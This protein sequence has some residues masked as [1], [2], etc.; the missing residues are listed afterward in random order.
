MKTTNQRSILS[1]FGPPK[2]NGEKKTPDS[3]AKN[4]EAIKTVDEDSPI[5]RKTKRRSR[6]IESDSEDEVIDNNKEKDSDNV[7]EE[8]N[9]DSNGIEVIAN[10]SK[11]LGESSSPKDNGKVGF[12]PE[13]VPPLRKTARKQMKRS[14]PSLEDQQLEIVKKL[15]S[16]SSPT[17]KKHVKGNRNESS[18]KGPKRTNCLDKFVFKKV[19]RNTNSESNPVVSSKN[20]SSRSDIANNNL[21]VEEMEVDSVKEDEQ[22][23]ENSESSPP[24]KKRLSSPSPKSP[25]KSPKSDAQTEIKDCVKDK[26]QRKATSESP[27]LKKRKL[28]SPS[29]KSKKS[30]KLDKKVEIKDCIKSE[31][32][33]KT[34]SESPPLKKKSSP[35]HKSPKQSPKLKKE[36]KVGVSEGNSDQSKSPKST[37]ELPSSSPKSLEAEELKPMN[38]TEKKIMNP[39]SDAKDK[40]EK[41]SYNP[42]K[43]NYDPI[44]D[45]LWKRNEDVPFSALS[46]TFEI[47]EDTS[48]RLKTVEILSNFLR[49]VIILSP[50]DLLFC[51]YL[52]M[53]KVAPSFEGIELGIGE[54]YVCRMVAQ[55]TGRSVNMIKNEI[56]EKGD[57]G[58]VAEHSKTNQRMMFQPAALTVKKVFKNLK[59][60]A[61]MSGQAS[62]A[63]KIEKIKTMFVACK[64]SEARFLIRLCGGKLR[65]GLAEQSVL[66][67][68]AQACYLTPPDQDFPPKVLN[69]GKGLSADSLKAKVDEFA[70]ILKTTYCECPTFDS[71]VPVLLEKGMKELPNHCKLE[72][73]IPLKPMLAHPTKGVSEVLKRFE[74]SKFTC[75]FKYDGE[76]A[77]IHLKEDGTCSIFS[78]NQENNTSKYPDII[79]R[80][81]DSLGPDV[82]SCVIDSEAV[83]YDVNEKKILPFQILSTRKRKDASED[84]IKVQV[85][86]F[87]FDLLYLNGRNLVTEPFQVRRDLLR[88]NFIEKEGQFTFAKSMD[89][90]NT[91]DIE[92]FL[93]ES[94]KGNCEGLMVKSLDVDATYEIAKRSHNWLKLKKDYLDGVGD[95]I[96]VVVIG[97][98][99]GKGKRTG[100]YG[101]FLLACYDPDNEEF[102]SLCKIGTGFS[103]DDLQ[104]HSSFLKEHVIE[105]PKSYYRYDSSVSPDHW[106]DAVQVWEIKCADLSIS[107]V[108]K[109]AI[110]IVDSEKGISLRFPRFLRIRE[111]KS[112]EDAT[113]ASQIA[114]LYRNQEQIKNQT[115]TAAVEEDFY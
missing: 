9:S 109:A 57:L 24:K 55:V 53:N 107:P 25:K 27:P 110:G 33:E 21:K 78:R 76:R 49:S 40:S 51:I 37:K 69:A 79:S 88:E 35:A 39:F 99:L 67:A 8:T 70:S 75:E 68:I 65:I 105:N 71:I 112:P 6:T 46:K 29:P 113:S 19:Q 61:L 111:D 62:Q 95:T 103:D 92:E 91:E 20:P 1:F 82:K 89:S 98:F 73:G 80:L 85:C 64:G 42:S 18:K 36:P 47:I 2:T 52:C 93:E 114:S 59:E 23:E 12:S 4:V 63:K 108:H 102:Q 22:R 100:T 90:T 34:T 28:N 32:Q 81:K 77:Q 17:E 86:V 10:C 101:G 83:A 14:S 7:K 84:E 3:K 44:E 26:E 115:E 72:P 97:G 66:Q 94:I 48:G 38:S 16:N 41:K 96:D 50:S 5:K 60:I 15:K 106:F 74:K 11:N 54:I 45:A 30:P 13:T 43:S 56:S 58:L 31:E 87:P 104:T